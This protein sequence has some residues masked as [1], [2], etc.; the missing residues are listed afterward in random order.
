MVSH[1]H[2]QGYADSN[3]VL[4]EIIE[5]VEVFKGPYFAELGDFAT[6]GAINLVS[7][8]RSRWQLCLAV[9]R[10]VQHAAWRGGGWAPFLD[11][12]LRALVV[13]EASY[14]DGPFENPER[15][16]K[17]NL[18]SKLT[19]QLTPSSGDLLAVTSYA[20]DWFAS[21]QIPLRAVESGARC[22]A[23]ATSIPPRGKLVSPASTWP[24]SWHSGSHDLS[25]LVLLL[26]TRC[27]CHS[28]FTLFSLDTQNGD[29]IEQADD[30]DL[31]GFSRDLPTASSFGAGCA[32]T[33]PW[34]S[35]AASD[36]IHNSL[37][38]QRAR[39]RITPIVDHD[40]GQSSLSLYATPR[41]DRVFALGAADCRPA[42]RSVRL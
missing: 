16:K 6:A 14:S 32:L 25:A 17:F 4:P 13:G 39:E 21:G 42:I 18:F 30:R 3:F 40:I 5:R 29:G 36:R 23:L 15:F 26:A 38:H 28:N 11:G 9:R 1:A 41:R 8:A 20:G 31:T 2:G 24:T 37:Y 35:P 22:R 19:Y 7:K 27:G 33:P 12:K 34:A 10:I